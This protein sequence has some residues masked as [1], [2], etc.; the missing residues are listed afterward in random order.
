M[1][2]LNKLCICTGCYFGDRCQ[3]YAKGIGLTLDDILRYQIRPNATLADQ[4]LSI[5]VSA[6]LTMIMFAAGLI[7]SVLSLMTF[8]SRDSRKVGCGMYLLASS[9]TSLLTVTMFTI[10]F[11]FVILTQMNVYVSHSVLR[12]GCI[13]IEPLLK[14][15]LY[16]DNWLNACVAVE[17]AVTVFK[18]IN[19]NQS[20]SKQIARWAILFLPVFIMGTIIHEPVY[21]NLFDDKE[22]QRIW[23]VTNYSH[24]VQIY[25]TFILFFHFL[26]PFSCNLFSAL[27]IIFRAARH[28]AK[29]RTEQTYKQHLREQLN[30]HKQLVI[31][32][33]IFVVL[34]LPRLI[35]SLL[36]GCVK[37]SRNPWLYLSGYFIS[38]IP[39]VI[40]FAAFV[41]PSALYKKQFK[42]SLNK[43]R[44]RFHRE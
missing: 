28:R 32:P 42:E 34:S 15:M 8:Q 33:L 13:S 19:L 21:R 4:S 2:P 3:F 6:A 29:T 17:R 1:C 41:L 35:I 9:I 37:S 39:S 22:E 10:K 40:V 16:T 5:K 26:V 30:E 44:R 20:R 36:S 12:G 43:W 38:F 24:A 23:C 11:W 7:N 31:S 14:L 27:F 18:G 25:N